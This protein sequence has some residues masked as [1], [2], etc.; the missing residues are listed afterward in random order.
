ML[1]VFIGIGLGVLLGSIP[2]LCG[3]PGRVETG[4]GG[5]TADYGVDPRAY[6]QYRQAVLVYAAKRQP[7]AAGAGDRAVPLGRWSEIWW[8]F[9]EYRSMAKG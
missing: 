6:R 7:R 2:S 1:P 3:I 8:G 5:R 4:A 9:C